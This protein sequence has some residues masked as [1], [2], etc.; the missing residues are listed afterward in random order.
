MVRPIGAPFEPK[1]IQ[2]E[3]TIESVTKQLRL[4]LDVVAARQVVERN[5]VTVAEAKLSL[6]NAETQRIQSA[7]DALTTEVEE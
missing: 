4:L 5:V 3:V 2:E 7:I 1:S 6:L